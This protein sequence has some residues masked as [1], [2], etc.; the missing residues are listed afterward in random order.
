MHPC[1]LCDVAQTSAMVVFGLATVWEW[2]ARYAVYSPGSTYS[3]G[4]PDG[5][6]LV[7]HYDRGWWL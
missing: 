1:V 3:L 2:H 4:D 6:G 5:L 7:R